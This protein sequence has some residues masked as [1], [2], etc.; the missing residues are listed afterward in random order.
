MAIK[1]FLEYTEQRNRVQTTLLNEPILNKQL[2]FL[3]DGFE[4]LVKITLTHQDQHSE[5][6]KFLRRVATE[7]DVL[8]N[9]FQENRS[10][11]L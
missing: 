10:K 11:R 3:E 4:I 8:S 1:S 2:E 6:A 9:V 5:A 7:L